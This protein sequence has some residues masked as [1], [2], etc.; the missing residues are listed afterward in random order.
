MSAR[1]PISFLLPAFNCG[2]FLPQAIK[3]ILNGNCAGDDEII[4]VDDASN[5]DTPEVIA[6]LA[7]KEPRICTA[8]HRSNRGS[9]AAGRNTAIELARHDLFFALDAD[10]L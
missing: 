10:N 4:I 3:S 2:K 7:A 8:R 9:A 6:S 1:P 5:D